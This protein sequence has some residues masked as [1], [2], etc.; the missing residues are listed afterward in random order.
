MPFTSSKKKEREMR[1]KP[2]IFAAILIVLLSG[3]TASLSSASNISEADIFYLDPLREYAPGEIQSWYVRYQPDQKNALAQTARQLGGEVIY[4][5]SIVDTL[6]IN[7]PPQ[8][9]QSLSTSRAV[10]FY[11]PVP[12]HKL[13]EDGRSQ[14]ITDAPANAPASGRVEVVPWNIDQYQA[15]EIWD[16]NFDGIVDPGA[17]TGEG[18][19]FCIIDTGLWREHEDFDWSNI[20]GF[21]QISGQA[22]DTDGNGHGTHVA[23]TANAV[24]NGIGVVGVAPGGM[25]LHIVKVFDNNGNWTGTSSLGAAAQNCRDNGGNVLSMSLGGPYS[26]TEEAIFQALY[27]NNNILNI[28][29]A[30]NSGNTT[31]SY[32]ASYDAVISVA[33]IDRNEVVATF[34]Q[35][36]AT[37]YN[38]NSPPANVEWDVVELSGGGVNVLSTWPAPPNTDVPRYEVNTV[39]GSNSA[40][41]AIEGAANGSASNLLVDGGLCSSTNGAWSGRIV[42]CERGSVNFDVK[43]NNVRNSGGLAIILFNNEPGELAATCGGNCT[44]PSIPGVTMSQADGLDLRNNYLNTTVEVVSDNGSNCPT[45]VGGYNAISGTSMATPGVAAAVGFTWAACGGGNNPNVTNK[46]IRQLL[47]DTAKDLQGTHGNGGA[48]GAG[49]DRMTGWGLVQL[50]DALDLGTDRFGAANCPPVGQIQI[51]P[52]TADICTAVTPSF[53]FAVTIE[54]GDFTGNYNMSAN[55][56]PAGASGSF[57]PNPILNPGSATTF[58]LSGL[59]N[60]AAGSHAVTIIATDA[61]DPANQSQGLLP[62]NLTHQPPG[63][64]VLMAPANGS[65]GATIAPQFTWNAIVGASSYAIVIATDAAF[66]NIVDSATGLTDPNYT[67]ASPLAY[68]TVYYWRV[69]AVNACGDG[70]ASGAFSFTTMD[71]PSE[72]I[73]CNANAITIPSSGAAVPYPSAITVI[74]AAS[75]LDSVKVH[76]YGLNHAWPD[77]IDILLVGPAGQNLII[78]SDA[79]GSAS[80]TN[81]N[82]TFD[83]AAAAQLPDSSQIV[84]GVYRPTN[85]GA[86][87]TF[88]APAPAPSAAT[89]LSLFNGTDPN[90]QWQLFV[91]DDAA[92]DSGSISGG[93]CVEIVAS[94]PLAPPSIMI[95][96]VS[97]VGGQ[98]PDVQANHPLTITNAGEADLIWTIDEALPAAILSA[99]SWATVSRQSGSSEQEAPSAYAPLAN[100]NEGFDNVA[101]LPGWATQN[102]PDSPGTTAWF[103]GVDTIFPAHSGAPTSYIAANF[104]NTGGSQISNW[105]MTP[106]VNFTPSSSISFWTR[107]TGSTFPDRLQVR[108]STAGASVNV[109]ATPGSVGDFTNL[110]LDINP[111]LTAGGYPA[112]W[113]QYTI[114]LSGYAGASGRVAFRYYVPTSA[115]PA[116][117]N[118]DYIGIDTVEFVE[119]ISVCDAPTDLPWLAV[120]SGGGAI[121]GGGSAALTVTFDSTG[122]TD[123]AYNG[124]LCVNSNDPTTPRVEVP[125]TLTVESLAEQII[126]LQAG[127]NII[128]SHIMPDNPD[129]AAVM[130]AV[131]DDLILVKNGTGQFYVPGVFNGIGDW[132]WSEGYLV[133]MAAPRSLIIVGETMPENAPITLGVGWRAI[134]YLPA[135]PMDAADALAS[136]NGSFGLVKNSAGQF[137][138]PGVFNGIGAL[139]PGQGYLIQMTAEDTLIYPAGD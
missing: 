68:A 120:S 41:N 134:T 35:Y 33:A 56:L 96:P 39:D 49:W 97:V 50:K 65:S 61:S 40:V 128:S 83:D 13:L 74:G 66:S 89:Q 91:V 104:N 84:S 46:D 20:T 62:I 72:I 29:A 137:Y 121:G 92:G 73:A 75:E 116:G 101:S 117:N 138:V 85:Y 22:W 14:F 48:Y 118:S 60:A 5:L 135:A 87:D 86:G 12:Q 99:P 25:V 24:Q 69:Y 11:E 31:K 108:V 21:S 4:D 7:L 136:I 26:A 15:R 52:A 71:E 125:V 6:V 55:N 114:D 80:L 38:P 94:D 16:Q 57:S 88:P 82:L 37:S 131:A 100:F 109:G 124:T 19:K 126:E 130:A 63:A 58:T 111:T 28:A 93:W 103:Q 32:P 54:R 98:T 81:V 8:A 10:A 51:T 132:Q 67:P 107:G 27:D 129:M 113:T 77:D 127:W 139:M 1:G 45:C 53:D 90:G 115:G 17:P 59:N 18:V 79:G 70:A 112:V 47:R 2:F 34:S 122:L 23:G 78:M 119:T 42:L 30:G 106:Q 95:D 123:G 76:L 9:I 64:P 110:E 36:P 3:L 133:Q 102:N 43:V 105:L 44:Q